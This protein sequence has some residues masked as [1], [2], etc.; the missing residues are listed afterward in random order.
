[1]KLTS[2][3]IGFIMFMTITAILEETGR[4]IIYKLNF[5]T[6]SIIII[7]ITEVLM[8]YALYRWLLK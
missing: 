4:Y 1:M 8:V 7:P 3:L 5:S 2:Q 6:I